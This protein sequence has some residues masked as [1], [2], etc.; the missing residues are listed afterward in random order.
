MQSAQLIEAICNE[1]KDLLRTKIKA[2]P[3]AY[4]RIEHLLW[5][6]W[7]PGPV[8]AF[9][10][11]L[12]NAAQTPAADLPHAQ[13]VKLCS[14]IT[15]SFLMSQAPPEGMTPQT[16]PVGTTS[17]S[18]QK[19]NA[20]AVSPMCS[21]LLRLPRS[22]AQQ[23]LR[24]ELFVDADDLERDEALRGGSANGRLPGTSLVS[25]VVACGIAV[26]A[27]WCCCACLRG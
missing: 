7:Q 14:P 22:A 16:Q 27:V 6:L 11:I 17:T 12:S 2:N 24:R 26:P 10:A 1:A 4:R 21:T 19:R 9:H 3:P 13:D 8:A 5:E 15:A 20:E 18:P 23:A 25:L